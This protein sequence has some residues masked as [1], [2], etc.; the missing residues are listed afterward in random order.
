[1][2]WIYGRSANSIWN[3]HGTGYKWSHFQINAEAGRGEEKIAIPAFGCDV[4]APESLLVRLW[5]YGGFCCLSD[6]PGICFEL[7][8]EF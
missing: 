8:V 6:G 1:M 7:I 2:K 3:C 4:T 5:T